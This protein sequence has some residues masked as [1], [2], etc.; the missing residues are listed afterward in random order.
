RGGLGH[1]A[2]R[3]LQAARA[4]HLPD[5]A[6]SPSLRARW[7]ERAESDHPFPHHRDR[8]RPVQPHDAEAAMTRDAMDLD[9]RHVVVLGAGR[10]GVAASELLAT[11]AARVT[12]V[13]EQPA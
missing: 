11:R 8:V 2:G 3:L 12:L 6:A 13:D 5:G 7:L 9:R 4:A 1:P 10:S